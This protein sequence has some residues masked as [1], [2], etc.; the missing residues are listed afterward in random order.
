VLLI[1]RLKYKIKLYILW[2]V[3]V[4]E[5]GFKQ[6]CTSGEVFLFDQSRGSE[7]CIISN[8]RGL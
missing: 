3:S 4:L 5:C 2:T 7:K 8:E 6:A 1:V